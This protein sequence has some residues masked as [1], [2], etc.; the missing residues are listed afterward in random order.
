MKLFAWLFLT[1]VEILVNVMIQNIN[2]EEVAKSASMLLLTMRVMSSCI[3]CFLI[4]HSVG[5]MHYFWFQWQPGAMLVGGGG[6]R[7]G[8]LGCDGNSYRE[9]LANSVTRKFLRG[10]CCEWSVEW[11]PIGGSSALWQETVTHEAFTGHYLGIWPL[12]KCGRSG[13]IGH[14]D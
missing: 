13:W 5:F 14:R 10:W 12:C 1:T 8:S 9:A 2:K 11:L 3:T 6:L 7:T 4:W